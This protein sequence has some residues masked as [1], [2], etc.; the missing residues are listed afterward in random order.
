[1][2]GVAFSLILYP[3]DNLKLVDDWIDESEF[4]R[5]P[6]QPVLFHMLHFS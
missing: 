5:F 2:F 6:F 3:V 4:Q 1:V